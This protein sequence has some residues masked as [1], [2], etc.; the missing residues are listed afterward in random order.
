MAQTIQ[1]SFNIFLIHL[2]LYIQYLNWL[3]LPLPNIAIVLTEMSKCSCYFDSDVQGFT[4]NIL[5]ND[6]ASELITG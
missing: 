2:I 6:H 5:Y 3:P 4:A 1:Y